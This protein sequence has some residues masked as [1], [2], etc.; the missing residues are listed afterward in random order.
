M[1]VVQKEN[2]EVAIDILEVGKLMLSNAL[3][4]FLCTLMCGLLTYAGVYFFVT[5]QYEASITM[6]VNNR[7]T[8]ESS[9]TVTQSDLNASAQLV[10]TYSAI[11]TSKSVLR[12]VIEAADVELTVEDLQG[13]ISTSAVNNTEV[14]EVTVLSEDPKAA[15]RIANAVASIAPEQISQIVEGSSVKVVDYADIPDEI[16]K[17]SY[18]KLVAVGM[19]LGFLAS[20]AIIFI[21]ELLDTSVKSEADFSQWNYPILSTIPDLDEGHKSRR[22]GYG[23]GYGSYGRRA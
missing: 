14:F 20:M 21:R 18:K 5:P 17:P 2:D 23:Y 8:A 9:T 7:A 16:A 4:I 15:A 12:E 22:N 11:I 3:V 1:N 10:D 13:V 19:L 6:Y